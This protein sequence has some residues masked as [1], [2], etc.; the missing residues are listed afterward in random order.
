MRW[1]CKFCTFSCSWQGRILQ[2]YKERHGHHRRSSGLV[3]IYEDCLNTF[4]TQAELKSHLT[5][6]GKNDHKIV[7]KLCCDLCTFSEP[8]NINKYFSHLKTHL[9]NKETVKCP[10]AD[11]FFKSS[12]LSTFTAHRSRCHKFSTLSNLRPELFVHRTFTNTVSGEECVSDTEAS[13]LC[14]SEAEPDRE[15]G[16]AVKRQLASL[17]LRM[18][19]ILHVSN[20]AVQEVIDELFDIGDVASKNI[21]GIIERVLEENNCAVDASVV[22]SLS[23]EIQSLNPLKCLS[24][25]GSLGTERKRQSFYRKNFAVVEPV[26]YVL[27]AQEKQNSFVYVPILQV[28]H[29]LLERSEILQTLQRSSQEEG[30]YNSFQDGEYFKENKLF[31]EELG[32]AL[33]LYIDEFEICNPLGT[34]KKIH[35]ICGIYWVILNLPIQFR[36]TLSSIYLA[37]LCKAIHIKQYGYS[38]VFE[39]LIRDLQYLE[40]TGVFVKRV[41]SCIKGTVLFVSA[42]NLGAHSLAGYQESFSVDKFCRFCLASLKDIQQYDV[43]SGAF[44]LRTPELFDEAVN[45]LNTTDASCIDGLKRDCPL[46]RLAHFHP[47]KGFPPDFLHDVLEGI[48]PVELCICL[49]DLIAKKYFTL[50]ELNDRIASFPFQFSDKTNRPQ[51]IQ[52]N[53]SKKKTIGGNGHENW[54]LLR[55][56]PLLIGHH[57]PENEKTWSVVLELKDIVELLSSPSFTTETLCYLQA[58]ISDH[59]QLLLETFPST[60]LRPKHH[61]IEHYPV[62]IK[63]Y[64][65]LTEFWTIRFEAKHSFFKK[66]VRNTGNF[67]NVLQTLATRH[68]LMLSYYL[69]M[70][71]IFKPNIETGRVSVV[72][73][74]ILDATIR[75]AIWNKF[76]VTKMLLRVFVSPEQIRRVTL[77]DIPS[78]VEDLCEVLRNNLGLRGNFILQ[79]EDPEFGNEL[80]NLTDIKDLPPERATLKV[81]F[82]FS[83]PLSDSTSDT[84]SLSS[85]SLSSPN[86]PSSCE[87]STATEWPEPFVIPSFTH[88]VE[89]QLRLANEA[90][91]TNGTLMAASKSMKSEILEKL[92]DC[93]IKIT[94]YPTRNN[95]ESVAKALVLKH[96]CLREPGSGQG[97]YG[98]KF[99]LVFKMGNYRQRM[100]AA[101]CPEVLINKRKRGQGNGKSV[102]KSKKGEVHYLPKPPEGQTAAE[103]EKDRS[104]MALEVQKREP[105]LQVLDNLMAATFWQRRQEIIGDEPLIA[106]VMDRWPALFSERQVI[107]FQF[108]VHIV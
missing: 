46:R 90:Y 58:K 103:A 87:D 88:D 59:R 18:Q 3:C 83:E 43:R 35:K 17:C 62:L 95:I 12:V 107:L 2:H 79:F 47:V 41:G 67:K 99:S 86:R 105:D 100:M 70:P 7:T 6:H 74:A 39:P 29:K 106:A 33:G 42:D 94:P 9:R 8:S 92:A 23:D 55:F 19:T 31:N 84:A 26:E 66:V 64:G 27:S 54:A 4:Q 24:R 22:T 52:T 1:K 65:P 76:Q 11:C 78:S 37:V 49:S 21:R 56:L 82:T 75:E 44:T 72:P 91:A 61:Y 36:S 15:Y 14:D 53:F 10:F 96:P 28:L 16:E 13:F 93:I 108:S 57:V 97:W 40:T 98:W 25:E 68:Q 60:K 104:T 89:F 50:N 34:S 102:K 81:I 38:K 80:C 30:H 63:K 77:L 101:G 51:K 32:I 85:D 71:T 69:E 5:E 45:V 48:V 20:S 73:V